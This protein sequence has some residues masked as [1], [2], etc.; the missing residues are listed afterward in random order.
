MNC[1]YVLG[2]VLYMYIYVH[3][4]YI[5]YY[6]WLLI[7][8][9]RGRH[10]H[11][12]YTLYIHTWSVNNCTICTYSTYQYNMYNV[13]IIIIYT[14]VHTVCTYIH[15]STY[16]IDI[17]HRSDLIKLYTVVIYTHIQNWHLS[18]MLSNAWHLSLLLHWD[19]RIWLLLLKSFQDLWDSSSF[20]GKRLISGRAVATLFIVTFVLLD[21]MVWCIKITLYLIYLN[22]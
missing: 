2:C 14:Y 21:I 5:T 3:V 8:I 7:R 22:Q 10:N 12:M 15:T 13:H 18:S 20:S 1:M 19:P 16:L 11:G 17:I 9:E 6:V 4:S